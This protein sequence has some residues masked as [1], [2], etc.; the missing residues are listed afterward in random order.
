[1]GENGE[2]DRV[3]PARYPE[4]DKDE[5]D[6][7]DI[8]NLL[9]NDSIKSFI[10]S[11]DKAPNHD[12]FLEIVDE[13]R[14]P[15]GRVVVQ[16]KKLPDRHSDTP[17][18][19]LETRHLAYCFTCIEPFLVITVDVKNEVAYWKH[20]TKDWFEEEELHNQDYKTVHFSDANKIS[21]DEN[22]YINQ[23]REIISNTRRRVDN[24]EEYQNLKKRSNPAIGKQ[25]PEF[26][27]IHQFLDQYHSLLNSDFQV[28]K[29]R[30]YENVWKFGFGSMA[31]EDNGLSYT[32][33]PIEADE[34]DAQIRDIDS[35][36]E[37]VHELGA[38]QFSSYPSHNPLADNPEKFAYN[39]LESRVEKLFDDRRLDYS[40]CPFLATEYVYSF[41]KKFSTL[42]GIEDKETYSVKEI[43]EGY[44]RYL[45]FWLA[46]DNKILFDEHDVENIHI[47]IDGYLE[48][49]RD[50]FYE[51]AHEVAKEKT[52]KAEIDPP[53]HRIIIEDFDQ[54]VLENMIDGLVESSVEFIEKPY[55]GRDMMD[56]G[57]E[58]TNVLDFYSDEALFNYIKTY[59]ENYH[60]ELRN[61]ASS[62]FPSICDEL[63]PERGN[64]LLVIVD[65][66]NL[67][68][69]SGVSI[70]RLWLDG[71]EDAFR[72]ECH[73]ASDEKAPQNYQKLMPH[74]DSTVSY[75]GTDYEIKISG[76][77][78]M[79]LS[80]IDR[81]NRIIF[82]EV[83]KELK[84]EVTSYISER[85]A[86]LNRTD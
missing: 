61:L 54:Y 59:Y 74:S 45:Q 27:P 26:R 13:D 42:L 11:R 14:A 82:D 69:L 56:V 33:Y 19:Q 16:V 72:V 75:E 51:H 2:D 52:D 24:Y 38:N 50:S 9:L 31:F 44:Y 41:V 6:A 67:R 78:G 85:Q 47:S 55:S 5:H 36:W 18:K 73:W 70:K 48:A 86:P 17:K 12:G 4:S 32:L 8:L 84:R 62:N 30:L 35:S 29:E 63:V 39:A 60:K 28:V 49:D 3:R 7:V 43:R 65:R 76:V 40:S 58:A 25:R 57:D 53:R 1:M 64:L 21:A 15:L 71:P 83:H 10:D 77:G 66:A 34:N 37:E 20:I 68:S 80:E 23:W 79:F 81:S 46:E 22:G